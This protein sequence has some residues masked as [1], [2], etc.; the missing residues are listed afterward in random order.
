MEP[1]FNTLHLLLGLRNPLVQT[2]GLPRKTDLP[3]GRFKPSWAGYQAL[4]SQSHT[5]GWGIVR[6]DPIQRAAR[7]FRHG[8]RVHTVFGFPMRPVHTELPLHL[9]APSAPDPYVDR[10]SHLGLDSTPEQ[11]DET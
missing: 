7:S 6:F 8:N 10:L 2:G 5:R 4:A 1:R 11:A 9:T 3:N